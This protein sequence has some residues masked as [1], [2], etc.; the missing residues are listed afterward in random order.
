MADLPVSVRMCLW[1]TRAWTS[2][3]ALADAVAAAHPDIGEVAGDVGRLA[4]WH[5]LGE[6]AVLVALPAPGDAYGMPISAPESL[7][8]AVA[9]GEC[10]VAP[11]LGGVLVPTVDEYGPETDRGSRVTWTAYDADPIRHHQI[12]ALELRTSTQELAEAVTVAI[13]GLGRL[14]GEPFRAERPLHGGEAA[15]RWGI[16]SACPP[17]RPRP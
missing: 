8:A 9:A 10:L 2:G 12:E 16:P 4:L 14:G 3:H 13:D 5:D 7:A 17:T 15:S 6:E 11:A 1:V